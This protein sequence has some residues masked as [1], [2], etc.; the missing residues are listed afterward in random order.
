MTPRRHQRLALPR[1][2]LPARAGCG[3][4]LRRIGGGG[5]IGIA[6]VLLQASVE[7]GDPHGPVLDDGGQMDDPW[8]HE[9]QG[10]FPPGGIERKP[11]WQWV[12]VAT[13]PLMSHIWRRCRPNARAAIIPCQRPI[14]LRYH[15]SFSSN[16]FASWRSAVSKPSVNQP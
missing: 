11:C 7:R 4:L 10:L 8:A 16:A 12:E 3:L 1:A 9:E 5:T 14:W 13:A 6:A 15:D 2:A